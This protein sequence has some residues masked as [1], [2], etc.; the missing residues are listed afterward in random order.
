MLNENANYGIREKQGGIFVFS[1]EPR[2]DT[3]YGGLDRCGVSQIGFNGRGYKR[4]GWNI[5]NGEAI[6]L[7]AAVKTNTRDAIDGNLKRNRWMGS[8]FEPARHAANQVALEDTFLIGD[9]V[10]Q[11][12]SPY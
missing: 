6:E 9:C 12:T 3:A 1:A 5:F 4:T 2:T 8:G 10:S 11:R 7:A